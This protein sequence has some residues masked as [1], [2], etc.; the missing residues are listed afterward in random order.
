MFW[1]SL[2]IFLLQNVWVSCNTTKTIY[3]EVKLI[4]SCKTRIQRLL[5]KVLIKKNT[6]FEHFSL[7][8]NYFEKTLRI[9][10][11]TLWTKSIAKILKILYSEYSTCLRYHRIRARL[12]GVCVETDLCEGS[13][14]NA[15]GPRGETRFSSQSDCQL[16]RRRAA[17]RWPSRRATESRQH[18][19][20]PPR[21]TA[22]YLTPEWTTN[23]RKNCNNGI[24]CVRSD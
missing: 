11:L 3:Y 5:K 15:S 19:R 6:N 22:A 18:T 2:K 20:L 24:V 14:S 8:I 13:R 4:M 10:Y 23:Y 21:A 16:Q 7:V 9:R 17:W 1:H 12:D